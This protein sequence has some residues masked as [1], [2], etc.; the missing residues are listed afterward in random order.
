[1]S[2]AC[3]TSFPVGPG[4]SIQR[5]RH[6]VQHPRRAPERSTVITILHVTLSA[7]PTKEKKRPDLGGSGQGSTRRMRTLTTLQY[8]QGHA[9]YKPPQF[10]LRPSCAYITPASRIKPFIVL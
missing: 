9:V 7:H 4:K 10:Y 8:T 2:L 6:H 1:M 5:P 3:R